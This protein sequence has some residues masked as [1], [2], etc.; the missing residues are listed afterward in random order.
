MINQTTTTQRMPRLCASALIACMSV[1]LPASSATIFLGNNTSPKSLASN[2]GDALPLLGASGGDTRAL[3]LSADDGGGTINMTF[4]RVQ[5]S[6]ATNSGDT[7]IGMDADSMGIGNDKWGD[8]SQG[9]EFTFDQTIDF[10]GMEFISGGTAI[11]LTSSAWGGDADGQTGTGW[12]FSSDGSTGT[13]RIQGAGDYDFSTGTFSSVS[14]GTS[15]LMRRNTGG[16]SGIGMA[17]FTIE[18]VPE[19]SSLAL[20]GLGGLLIARRR[21]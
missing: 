14:A 18:V 11:T 5:S 3:T 16:G 7:S 21:R 17:S 1:A 19:P 13:L 6:I 15:M 8:P 10:L 20:L 12:T 9:M 2:E 4:V